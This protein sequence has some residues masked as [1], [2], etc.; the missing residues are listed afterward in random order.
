V[1]GLEHGA[2]E[3][4]YNCPGGCPAEVA[5][6]Q[7]FIDGLPGDPTCGGARPR[8]VLAPAPLLDVRW[9]ASAWM[10]TL[11]SNTFDQAAF[12][13]FFQ[14][15]YDHAPEVICQGG[16]DLSPTGWCP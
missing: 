8:V 5:S 15:H 13:Q 12:L 14:D 3:I 11:R 16:I 10:W 2:V 1:H 4:F 6:A 9:A 7:T